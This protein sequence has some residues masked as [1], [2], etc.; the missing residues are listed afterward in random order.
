ME[1]QAKLNLDST[2]AVELPPPRAHAAPGPAPVAR[3]RPRVEGKYLFVGGQKLWIKGVT[4]GT[5]RP[6]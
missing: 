5:F 1:N 4:Y 3:Q 2:H 6:E